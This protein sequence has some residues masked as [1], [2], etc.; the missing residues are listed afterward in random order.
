M[1][2]ALT[3]KFNLSDFEE[4]YHTSCKSFF[5]TQA[6]RFEIHGAKTLPSYVDDGQFMY[7]TGVNDL[8]ALIS[9]K[10]LLSAGFKVVRLWDLND[11]PAPE[12]C[13]LTDYVGDHKK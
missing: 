5:S 9:E 2:D 12:W 6:D 1:A 4:L 7:W 13:L 3:L 8:Q 11:N 10:I